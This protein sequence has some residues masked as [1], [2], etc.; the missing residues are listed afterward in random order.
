MCDAAARVR[1][2][3]ASDAE[4][5]A[6]VYR[7][8]VSDTAVSFEES[9]PDGDEIRRRMQAPPR[10][11]WFVAERDARIVGFCYG[12]QHR[13]RPAYRWSVDCSVYVADTEQRRGTGRALY[14]RLLAELAALGYVSA[15]A[16]VTIPNDASKAFHESLGFAPLG[17]YRNAGFKLGRWHDVAWLQRPLREPPAKPPE[18][19]PWNA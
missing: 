7:P 14:V 2:A 17:V 8:Y 15:F 13:R 3:E 10:L 12:S 6:A 16:G 4:H 9:P 1:S 5:I 18:P 19:L 11:P